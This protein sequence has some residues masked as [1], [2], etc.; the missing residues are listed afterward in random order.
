M[1]EKFTLALEQ[2]APTPATQPDSI[3]MMPIEQ[4]EMEIKTRAGM[5][6]ENII[7]IGKMLMDVKGRL[8]HGQFLNWLRDKVNFSQSTANNFMRIA[9]EIPRTPGLVSLPYTKALALLDVPADDREQ[10]A[11]DIKADEIS[12]REIQRLTK[13]KE[14]AEK[15]RITAENLAKE[16]AAQLAVQ[17]RIASSQQALSEQY[18]DKYYSEAEKVALLESQLAAARSA[19]PE[20][21]EVPPADYEQLKAQAAEAKQRAEEAEQYAIEQETAL[22]RTQTELRKLKETRAEQPLLGN[23]PLSLDAFSATIKQFISQLGMAPNMAPFFR[24]MGPDTLHAYGQW[25]DVL[26]DWVEGTKEAIGEGTQYVDAHES[27]VV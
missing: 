12:T 25:V 9:R 19:E 23:S 7:I 13:E 3:A 14:D 11:Q 6:T 15:A 18:S 8:E 20:K 4:I 2:E 21:V 17:T 24:A 27:A 5:I 22:Q 1:P 16:T 26:A 10:F